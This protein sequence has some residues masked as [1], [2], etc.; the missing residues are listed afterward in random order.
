MAARKIAYSYIRF[1]SGK[2]AKGNS[3][4]RQLELSEDY[5]R[6]NGLSLDE[7]LQLRDLGVSAFRGHNVRDGALAGFLEACKTGKVKPGSFLIVESLD[8]LS[9]AEIRPAL[10]LF[11]SI[12]DYGVTIVTL[13]P[14]RAYCPKS[15]DAL[16]LIEPLI[17]FSRGHEES[18]IKS[19]RIHDAW[20]NKRK[21]AS[22]KPM[23]AKCPAW[24]TLKEGKFSVIPSAEKAI[25]RIYELANSGEGI[26]RITRI[27]V[28]E[29]IKP[30]GY[31]G[32]WTM[33]YVQKLLY[34]RALMGEMQPYVLDKG[35]R[36]P[37]GEPVQNYYPVVI[38]EEYFYQTRSKQK[39]KR[40][41][42]GRVSDREANLF[43]HLVVN[44]EDSMSMVMKTD[45]GQ[46]HLYL[47]SSGYCYGK[48]RT[49]NSSFPYAVFES[50]MLNYLYELKLE[51]EKPSTDKGENRISLLESQLVTIEQKIQRAIDKARKTD[52]IDVYLEVIEALKNDKKE[53]AAELES[54]RE[55][56]SSPESVS[57]VETR[58][59]I[60]AIRNNNDVSVRKMAKRKIAQLISKIYLMIRSEGRHKTA[61]AQI[62][63]RNGTKR[64]LIILTDKNLS[65]VINTDIFE[66][67]KKDLAQ[68]VKV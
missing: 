68:A 23:T 19:N 31:S 49:R 54:L 21:M 64:S 47:V 27:L 61:L 44:A 16:A 22:S 50:A 6:R 55:S 11:M 56:V 58:T 62:N 66:W 8:R 17:V 36:V 3:L 34:S 41:K 10:Q 30:I 9:R 5:C 18:S 42:Q 15:T 63:M 43:T 32:R 53:K 35:K 59:M 45:I 7:S 33:A 65:P 57:I 67:S 13:N 26:R 46:K 48:K 28:E 1:S 24:L 51:P 29:K 60:E 40:N 20:N 12:Q 37:L 38:S 14:E 52:D 39:Q 4:R 25:K 2:Q